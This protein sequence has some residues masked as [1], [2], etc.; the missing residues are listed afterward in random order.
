MNLNNPTWNAFIV[1]QRHWIDGLIASILQINIYWHLFHCIQ[2]ALAH[3]QLCFPSPVF[4]AENTT[5]RD[6]RDI[7][8][9]CLQEDWRIF[10]PAFFNK[11]VCKTHLSFETMATENKKKRNYNCKTRRR[12]RRRRRKPREQGNL[13]MNGS[14]PLCRANSL[15]RPGS[16]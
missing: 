15:E 11:F 6:S 3:L 16:V 9:P 13:R 1:M 2:A 4:Q 8:F 12:R 10:A 14:C 5:A 7:K